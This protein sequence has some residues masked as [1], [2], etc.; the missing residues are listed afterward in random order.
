MNLENDKFANLSENLID[1]QSQW[2]KI[3]ST[4][5]TEKN[6]Y[7]EELNL[8][9]HIVDLLNARYSAKTNNQSNNNTG[10]ESAFNYS[11]NEDYFFKN[12]KIYFL[13]M[14]SK[15]TQR[16][17]ISESKSENLPYLIE[18]PFYDNLLKKYLDGSINFFSEKHQDLI[19]SLAETNSDS[20]LKNQKLSAKD[21]ELR[22]AKVKTLNFLLEKIQERIIAKLNYT[23]QTNDKNQ[24]KFQSET[25]KLT[26]QQSFSNQTIIN[27]T[28]I[29]DSNSKRISDLNEKILLCEGKPLSYKKC[30][31]I[32]NLKERKNIEVEVMVNKINEIIQDLV[33][34]TKENVTVNYVNATRCKFGNDSENETNQT[35][36]NG[37]QTS[38]NETNSNITNQNS[39]DE[40]T[41][42]ET[43]NN[44]QENNTNEEDETNT[45]N[46]KNES[47]GDENTSN[48][49]DNNSHENNAN[50]E[51]ETI[52]NNTNNE[53]ENI[54]NN[55]TENGNTENNTSNNESISN[56]STT[57]Q[58]NSNTSTENTTTNED[59]NTES[60]D[61]SSTSNNSK[62]SNISN[63][64]KNTSQNNENSTNS[65]HN[66][67]QE[68]NETT[69]SE[70]STTNQDNTTTNT[71]NNETNNKSDSSNTT[72]NQN[73]TANFNENQLTKIKNIENKRR[74]HLLKEKLGDLNGS[75]KFKKFNVLPHIRRKMVLNNPIYF[76]SRRGLVEN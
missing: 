14:E 32:Y 45:N 29:I 37:G 57:N 9:S 67:N 20:L 34:L 69:D 43:D 24:Q 7:L 25:Q 64:N 36:D 68:N 76:K 60:I 63:E 42:N 23:N 51:D 21:I 74:Q 59:N 62:D 22:L 28:Q 3:N 31:Q 35:E 44:G 2:Q 39:G 55:E 16:E 56:E 50:K 75:E 71:S 70:N 26:D 18:V 5:E 40:N 33:K 15:K 61:N 8:T 65:G 72:M 6:K 27:L 38:E 54:T 49:T 10:N 52:T 46:T 4:Y 41:S 13:D 17:K 66:N 12:D 1:L 30:A 48:E 19:F 11:L 58:E 47:S 53:D 73:N